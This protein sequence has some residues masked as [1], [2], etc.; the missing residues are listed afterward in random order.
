MELVDGDKQS[1]FLSRVLF[2]FNIRRRQVRQMSTA[3][4][5]LEAWELCLEACCLIAY[6]LEE[7]SN[8]Q[9]KG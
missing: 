2:Q 3:R 6:V 4:L 8:A 9:G 1:L 7:M 5:N